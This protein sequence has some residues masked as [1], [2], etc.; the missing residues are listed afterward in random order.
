MSK[1][2]SKRKQRH[3]KKLAPELIVTHAINDVLYNNN[4]SLLNIEYQTSYSDV[5]IIFIDVN[6]SFIQ[7]SLTALQLKVKNC[8]VDLFEYHEFDIEWIVSFY[9]KNQSLGSINSE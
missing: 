9:S 1:K 2:V 7:S 3:L 4:A 8:L 5:I 6:D